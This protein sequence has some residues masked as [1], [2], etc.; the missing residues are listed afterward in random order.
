M[1]IKVFN[2][3]GKDNHSHIQVGWI[4]QMEK[5]FYIHNSNT[6]IHELYNKIKYYNS[7]C[8]DQRNFEGH[9]DEPEDEI[10]LLK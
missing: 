2:L 9:D 3:Y 10:S 8:E 4:T 6:S 7:I 1:D 5:K